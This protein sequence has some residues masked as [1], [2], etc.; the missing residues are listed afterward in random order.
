MPMLVD[1]LQHS[2]AG[3][4]YSR[5]RMIR[6]KP[7][8]LPLDLIAFQCPDELKYASDFFFYAKCMMSF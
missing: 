1:F 2:F 6:S 4:S 3:I 8:G 5:L 7:T